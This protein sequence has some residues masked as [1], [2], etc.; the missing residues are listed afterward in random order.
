MIVNNRKVN[1]IVAFAVVVMLLFIVNFSEYFIHREA[2]HECH[3]E[4]CSIC[5]VINQSNN[6]LSSILKNNSFKAIVLVLLCLTINL[7]TSSQ[8]I[9]KF[10][11]VNDNIRLNE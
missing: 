7:T 2:N 10:S 3:D 11:L 8:N 4:A 1:K 6:L 9:S 5:V